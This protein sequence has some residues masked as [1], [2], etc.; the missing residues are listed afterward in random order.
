MSPPRPR[1]IATQI[2]E[3]VNRVRTVRD[4]PPLRFDDDLASIAEAHSQD[5]VD[6]EFVGHSTPTGT[7]VGERYDRYGY[8]CR[9]SATGARR[10]V[11]AGENIAKLYYGTPSKRSDGRTVTYESASELAHGAVWGWMNSPGHRENLL[12]SSWRRE[13]I[14]VVIDG[15]RVLITQNFC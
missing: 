12:K 10:Y 6:R 8:E 4:N 7:S 5:M 11:T 15:N 2:H 14:G 9:V 13:G 1:R 3:A